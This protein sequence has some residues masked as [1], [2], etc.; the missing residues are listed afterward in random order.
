MPPDFYAGWRFG[1]WKRH[2]CSPD[3][4]ILLKF[5]HLDGEGERLL[6]ERGGNFVLVPWYVVKSC[7][8]GPG[9]SGGHEGSGDY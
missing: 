6:K 7:D 4:Q 3:Q 5:E 9:V 2:G 1:L 8:N